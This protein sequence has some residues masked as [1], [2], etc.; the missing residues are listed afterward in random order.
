MSY[1]PTIWNTGDI[2]TAEKLNKLEGGVSN[3]YNY[4]LIIR[5]EYDNDSG[6]NL[7]TGSGLSVNELVAKATNEEPISAYYVQT[8]DTGY[9]TQIKYVGGNATVDYSNNDSSGYIKLEITS[10]ITLD[11]QDLGTEYECLYAPNGNVY[12]YTYNSTTKE[13]T[14]TLNGSTD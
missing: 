14:F 10:R 4:D 13:Y 9:D 11:F 3:L 8:S 2:I 1:T 6:H 12:T 5:S 7:L